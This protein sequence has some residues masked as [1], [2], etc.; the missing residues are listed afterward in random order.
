MT[1]NSDKVAVLLNHQKSVMH[2]RR[3]PLPP[4]SKPESSSV[5]QMAKSPNEFN[6]ILSNKKSSLGSVLEKS[7]SMKIL[8]RN[9]SVKDVV[10]IILKKPAFGI[11]HYNPKP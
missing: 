2:L 7:Q 4:I 9:M 6:S 11:D 5:S 8:H 10:D 1:N 3:P